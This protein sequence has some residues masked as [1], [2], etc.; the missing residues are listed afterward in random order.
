[1]LRVFGTLELAELAEGI[2]FLFTGIGSLELIEDVEL[3]PVNISPIL[4]KILIL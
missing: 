3:G 2:E 4:S 1:M